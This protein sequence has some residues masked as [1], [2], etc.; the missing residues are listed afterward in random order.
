VAVKYITAVE[1]EPVKKVSVAV[2]AVRKFFISLGLVNLRA[3][4]E[5]TSFHKCEAPN[6]FHLTANEYSLGLLTC[7]SRASSRPVVFNL[8]Y[9]YPRGYANTS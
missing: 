2:T 1:L 5:V 6:G 7:D 4:R 3:A 8:G 9:A